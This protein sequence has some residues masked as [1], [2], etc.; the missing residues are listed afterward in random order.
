MNKYLI[1]LSRSKQ[2]IVTADTFLFSFYRFSSF[3][4]MPPYL[5]KAEISASY[6][7]VFLLWTVSFAFFLPAGAEP[8]PPIS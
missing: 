7:H 6:L 4:W 1:L 2:D 8:I 5:L 3:F